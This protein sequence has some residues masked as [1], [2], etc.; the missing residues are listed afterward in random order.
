MK[1]KYSH[2]ASLL[3]AGIGVAL[4]AVFGLMPGSFIGGIAG[5]SLAKAVFGTAVMPSVLLRIITALGMLIGVLGAGLIFTAGGAAL[6]WLLGAGVD[7]LPHREKVPAE[8][9]K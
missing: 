4:F 7:A 5:L 6:G 2:K 8:A 9:H 1:T 3:G